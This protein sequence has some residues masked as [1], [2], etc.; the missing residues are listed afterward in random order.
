MAAIEQTRRVFE[1]ENLE[2]FIAFGKSMFGGWITT[3][4]GATSTFAMSY[5]SPKNFEGKSGT[6]YDLLFEKQSGSDSSL[7]ISISAPLGFMW[8]ETG[9][10]TLSYVSAD[11]T[12][13]V[14]LVGTIVSK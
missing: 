6:V 12:G 14:H 9:S 10:S 11:P 3:N 7:D 2:R 1:P 8:K 13:R 4:A 5:R